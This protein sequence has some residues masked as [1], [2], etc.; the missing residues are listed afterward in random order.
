MMMRDNNNREGVVNL[1]LIMVNLIEDLDNFKGLEFKGLLDF[2]I[3]NAFNW[4]SS[5]REKN[6]VWYAVSHVALVSPKLCKE[7]LISSVI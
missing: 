5:I 3:K 4:L 7:I 6:I 2:C 1:I